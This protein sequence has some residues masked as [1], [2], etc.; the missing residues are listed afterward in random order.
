MDNTTATH[1]CF[2]HRQVDCHNRGSASGAIF[3]FFGWIHYM[4]HILT[5][6][7]TESICF[8]A[9]IMLCSVNWKILAAATASAPPFTKPSTKCSNAPTPHKAITGI[10]T[11]LDTSLIKRKSYPLPVP[12]RSMEFKRISPAPKL[13]A[14]LH[15]STGLRRVVFWPNSE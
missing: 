13:S 14:S 9:L 4:V 12:S 2:P 3:H 8:L 7:P 11:L 15:H 5:F 10:E 1:P 6:I